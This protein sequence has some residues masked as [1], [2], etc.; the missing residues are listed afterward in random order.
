[1]RPLGFHRIELNGGNWRES[2]WAATFWA[3]WSIDRTASPQW[4][5]IDA[6]T[7]L[8][9][10]S[11][12]V[13]QQWRQRTALCMQQQASAVYHLQSAHNYTVLRQSSPGMKTLQSFKVTTPF[14]CTRTSAVPVM[15][16][17]AA[18][19]RRAT[20]AVSN[21]QSNVRV[22]MANLK[23]IRSVT[24]GTGT[25][26]KVNEAVSFQRHPSRAEDELMGHIRVRS[27]GTYG[28]KIHVV[29]GQML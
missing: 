16:R 28:D 13:C 29:P 3:T 17:E 24:E 7:H 21:D 27:R 18:P 26:A 14:F 9:E 15:A 22:P 5:R 2:V 11:H 12:A 6:V 10:A 4:Y 23:S 19:K 25:P 1:M 20:G 8:L